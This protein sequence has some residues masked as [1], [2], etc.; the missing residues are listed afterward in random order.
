MSRL[1]KTLEQIADTLE[2]IAANVRDKSKENK[3]S[4]NYSDTTFSKY[5]INIKDNDL[6][7]SYPD[8]Y[9]STLFQNKEQSRILDQIYSAITLHGTNPYFHN[10]KFS[11]LEKDWPT[12]H[13]ALMNLIKYK[14]STTKKE[15]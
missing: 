12:L 11:E 2:E 7:I 8:K 3:S 4:S 9:S 5:R 14:Q 10:K 13:R 15:F 6:T 1:S